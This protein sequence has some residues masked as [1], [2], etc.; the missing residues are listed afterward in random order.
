MDRLR[1]LAA[2][3][4]NKAASVAALKELLA[5]S[6]SPPLDIGSSESCGVMLSELIYRHADHR[7][8]AL[9][10]L[11]RAIEAGY[12]VDAIVTDAREQDADGDGTQPSRSRPMR[13]R[14]TTVKG[15]GWRAHPSIC[16]S[17]VVRTPLT[18]L[19]RRWE[20]DSDRSN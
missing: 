6:A 12:D 5:R 17:N 7:A 1:E 9:S 13:T 2:D 15:W 20:R 19:S 14:Q 10:A 3:D 8:E 18:A 16:R 4:S 11:A